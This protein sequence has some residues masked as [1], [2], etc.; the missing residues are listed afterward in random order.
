MS[1][2]SFN[3]TDKIDVGIPMKESVTMTTQNDTLKKRYIQIGFAVALY[4]YKRI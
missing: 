3:S 4:W 1:N 2:S